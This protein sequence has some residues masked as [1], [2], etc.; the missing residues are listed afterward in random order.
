MELDVKE[1]Y[2]GD[3]HHGTWD[4]G[5]GTP[6]LSNC[7]FCYMMVIINLKLT[8]KILVVAFVHSLVKG[9]L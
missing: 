1:F 2:E 6:H 8:M 7:K 4:M 5:Y 9:S 3:A